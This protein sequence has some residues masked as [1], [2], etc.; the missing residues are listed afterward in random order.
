[1]AAYANDK[2]T[3]GHRTVEFVRVGGTVVIIGTVPL[4]SAACDRPDD[5]SQ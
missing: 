1:M 5:G 4:D 3:V 2:A